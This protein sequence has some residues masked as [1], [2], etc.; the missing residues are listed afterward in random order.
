MTASLI[1]TVVNTA[2]SGS[3]LAFTISPTAGNALA[4]CLDN[5]AAGGQ[6]ITSIKDQSNNSLSFVQNVGASAQGSN[7]YDVV[8]YNLPSSITSATVTFSGNTD[9]G[10]EGT[11]MEWSGLDTTSAILNVSTGSYSQQFFGTGTDQL[12]SGG[13]VL[14]AQP[15][16]LIGHGRNNDAN[17]IPTAGTGFTSVTTTALLGTRIEYKRTTATGSQ[18]ATFTVS[19]DNNHHS[20]SVMALLEATGGVASIFSSGSSSSSGSSLSYRG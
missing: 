19:N 16:I 17:A 13:A 11:C 15:A 12:S 9:F 8:V 7:I 4:I 3:T 14:T 20:A 10:I 5:F 2:G 1:Q 18:A 6:T